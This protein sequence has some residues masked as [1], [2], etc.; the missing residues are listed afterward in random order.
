MGI[1]R[2]LCCSEDGATM[3]EYGLITALIS[4]SIIAGMRSMGTQM[5]VIFQA[6]TDA[7]ATYLG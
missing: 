7:L 4:V 3:V 1:V 2:R 5:D 6:I